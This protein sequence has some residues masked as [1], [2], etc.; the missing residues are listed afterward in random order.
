M[1]NVPLALHYYNPIPKDH[2][3]AYLPKTVT[4]LFAPRGFLTLA[5]RPVEGRVFTQPRSEIR[6]LCP[7]GHMALA[8]Y[9][10]PVKLEQGA[11]GTNIGPLFWVLSR[12]WSQITGSPLSFVLGPGL[13]SRCLKSLL[14]TPRSLSCHRTPRESTTENP[15]QRCSL[16][17]ASPTLMMPV[18]SHTR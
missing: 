5:P 14:E 6:Q 1:C 16:Q 12:A 4:C 9:P 17:L 15:G 11:R 2:S 7:P 3:R 10:L 18:S 8:L 13:S